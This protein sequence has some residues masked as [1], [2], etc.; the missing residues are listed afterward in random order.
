MVKGTHKNLTNR[1]Q[2]HLASL[3]PRTATTAIPGYSNTPEKQDSDLKSHLMMMVDAF[4][5][6][7]NYSLKKIKKNTA[8]QVEVL[9]E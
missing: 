6:Y 7:I 2:D 1:K 3:E 4:K 5:K 9:K 8:K